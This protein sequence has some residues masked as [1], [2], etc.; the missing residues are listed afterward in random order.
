M[1]A[2]RVEAVAKIMAAMRT[3]VQKRTTRLVANMM[4]PVSTILSC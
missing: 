4:I 3:I 2:A 1:V